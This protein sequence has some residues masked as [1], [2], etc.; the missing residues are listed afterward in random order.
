MFNFR[1]E[2][3]S[4][5]CN[6]RKPYSPK[7][8]HVAF[9]LHGSS[10]NLKEKRQTIQ[11]LRLTLQNFSLSQ[12]Q[13]WF[14]CQHSDPALFLMYQ[15]QVR[16]D[17]AGEWMPCLSLAETRSL[18]R[19]P[20]AARALQ[21]GFFRQYIGIQAALHSWLLPTDWVR[22]AF[23]R[24]RRK[25]VHWAWG[26]PSAKH[27]GIMIYC[28]L[29]KPIAFS[30]SS[31][32]LCTFSL[33]AGVTDSFQSNSPVHRQLFSTNCYQVTGQQQDISLHININS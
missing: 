2:A 21:P 7:Y 30:L 5:N 10:L 11:L 33:L 9:L 15:K 13:H 27:L 4:Q 1:G 20:A 29:W 31:F 19:L 22:I 3:A 12:E 8:L 32:S 23:L 18:D 28:I 14:H 6:K 17:T 16:L 25:R 26:F 24:V